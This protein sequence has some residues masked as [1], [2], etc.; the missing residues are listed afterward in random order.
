MHEI[1]KKRKAIVED[2]KAIQE[3]GNFFELP[4]HL[5]QIEAVKEIKA[6]YGVDLSNYLFLALHS[7]IA[8]KDKKENKL[9][10]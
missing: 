8:G 9:K 10:K 4:Q 2:L 1:I 5:V 6:D 3:I 7:K